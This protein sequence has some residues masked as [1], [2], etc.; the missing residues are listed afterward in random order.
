M[1][2][3][4]AKNQPAKAASTRSGVVVLATLTT[5]HSQ[6]SI[7]LNTRVLAVHTTLNPAL[8]R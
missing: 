2:S 7:A 5:H 3:F 8:T 6:L 1:G 4:S